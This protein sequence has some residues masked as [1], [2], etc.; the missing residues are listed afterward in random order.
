MR[1]FPILLAT[2]LG[3]LPASL[4]AAD[5]TSPAP[6]APPTT[7]AAPVPPAPVPTAPVP[8]AAMATKPTRGPYIQCA[9]PTGIKIVWRTRSEGV[10]MVRFGLKPDVLDQSLP[11]DQIR[12]LRPE[13]ELPE[14]S[15]DPALNSGPPGTRQFEAELTG[16]LPDTLY[17]YG[18]G[19]DNKA[20]AT[21]ADGFSFRTLPTP[22]TARNALFWVV[23]DSG[24]GNKV[25]LAVHTAMRDWL[26]KEKRTLD[27]Y[28][29]VGDMAYGSGLD[30]EFQGYFFESYADTLRNTVC[31]PA[32]GNHEGRHSSG[33]TATGP[34]FDA[35]VCPTLGESGGVASGTESY[36]SFDFGKIHFICLNSHDLPRDPAGTMAQWLKADLD[37]SKADWLIAFWHHPPYT[38]GS[39]DSD[40]ERQ[41]VEMR[42]MIMPILESGGVDLVLTGHS[43]IYERS[44]LMD[45]AYAT[46]TVAENVILNDGDGQPS[47]NGAYRKSAG[48]NPNGGTIQ[49]VAGHGGTTLS[50]KEKPS[51]VMRS[52]IMEFGSV[53]LDLQGN[54]LN[55]LMLNSDGA[56][57]DSF[58]LIKEGQVSTQRIAKPWS[59]PILAGAR[60]LPIKGA[61]NGKDTKESIPLVLSPAAT[62]LIPQGADWQ[63][64]TNAKPGFGWQEPGFSPTG[65]LT[66][67]AGFGYSDNDDATVLTDMRGHYKFLCLRHEFT[68]NG[69]ERPYQFRLNVSYDDGFIAYLN[70]LEVLRV[71]AESGSL[72]SVRGVA[73]HEANKKFEVFPLDIPPGLL[74]IGPNVLAIEAYND[75]LDSSDLSI[76]PSL[77]LEPK[78]PAKPK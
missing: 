41:L 55:A 19:Q 1:F 25:Q 15:K 38:K 52:T 24:T 50:R 17:Y 35:Y 64:L 49:V 21:P 45:G 57:R 27:G 30:S 46:P 77:H 44:M 14:D 31:W 65:W 37:K 68:L 69:N 75:D 23:G 74:R 9:T 8:P 12:I 63:Y 22:G 36:Y 40:K 62:T 73:P 4:H 6:P 20:L 3:Q 5:P 76:H 48:L 72:D 58:Q 10:P 59:P 66:G 56:V 47:G 51:P 70:G 28:L 53:L 67:K 60:T 54:T 61:D 43:H 26:K 32:L 16:L 78:A 33:A 29:H 18:V 34:Y 11:L 2:V 7:Q 39:H 71:N 13:V 42:S